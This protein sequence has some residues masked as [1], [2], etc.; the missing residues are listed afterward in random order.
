MLLCWLILAGSAVPVHAAGWVYPQHAMNPTEEDPDG[1]ARTALD[2]AFGNMRDQAYWIGYKAR[3]YTVIPWF[4]DSEVVD[5]WEEVSM[6]GEYDGYRGYVMRYEEPIRCEILGSPSDEDLEIVGQ[7]FASLNEVPGFPGIAIDENVEDDAVRLRILFG[8]EEEAEDL[9]DI[10][11]PYNSWGFANVW[12]Y[13]SGGWLGV[14]SRSDVW[15]CPDAYPPQSRRSV[16][17][18]E[19]VQSL[20]M[21]NDPDRGYYSIFEQNSNDCDWPSDIDWAVIRIQYSPLL[22]AGMDGE[23]A[24]AA[25]YE[26]LSSLR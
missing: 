3:Q 4:F 19:I 6:Y 14:I 18:E 7:L 2:M 5:Y 20:G 17:C 13:T 8:P 10:E 15:I 9:F 22:H 21:L 1:R 26:V 11:I 23:T 24:R 12:R 16:I 25:A